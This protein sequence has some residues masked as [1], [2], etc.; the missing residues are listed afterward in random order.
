MRLAFR[1]FSAAKKTVAV[2]VHFGIP[3]KPPKV[4][5]T[6]SQEATFKGIRESPTHD[7]KFQI[8]VSSVI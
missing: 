3:Q 2:L 7:L 4:S 6:H 1:I 8:D 5:E